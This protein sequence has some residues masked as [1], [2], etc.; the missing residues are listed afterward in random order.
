MMLNQK[1]IFFVLSVC[2]L[3]LV[4]RVVSQSDSSTGG[5]TNT[6][7]LPSCS[8]SPASDNNCGA[9]D[10][11]CLCSQAALDDFTSC[12]QNSCSKDDITQ[13]KVI[14]SEKC[15]KYS[16]SHSILPCTRLS[17]P[18]SSLDSNDDNRKPASKSPAD[19]PTKQS[20]NGSISGH[21]VSML[22][23]FT[24]AFTLVFMF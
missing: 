3:C 16:R 9:N 14:V 11:A 4:D 21:N 12:L 23:V 18:G 15:G 6:S 19:V 24:W 10:V 22:V 1:P 13:G 5:D 7:C 8:A 17:F 20:I 2:V